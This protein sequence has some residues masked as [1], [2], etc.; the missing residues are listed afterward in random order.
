M[1]EIVIDNKNENIR[2][3]KYLQKILNDAP[4]SFIYKNIR[5]KNIVLNDKKTTYN[6]KLQIGDVIKLYLSDETI[7]K[8]RSKKE[9]AK[10]NKSFEIIYEDENILIVNKPVGL[11]SQKSAPNDISLNEQLLSYINDKGEIKDDFTPG[12]AHR[13]DRNTQGLV[14]MPKNNTCAMTISEMIKNKEI[15]KYYKTIVAG[16]IDDTFELKGTLIKN[17]ATNTVEYNSDEDLSNAHAIFTPIK[18]GDELTLLEVD[19]RTGKTHQIR[20][21]LASI[22]H[23]IIGDYKYGNTMLNDKYKTKFNI[24]SQMLVAYK[25]VF[26][27]TFPLSV[28]NLNGKIFTCKENDKF[29]LLND[30]L[31]EKYTYQKKTLREELHGDII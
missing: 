12:I 29:N 8:F 13:L 18:I 6:K 15:K 17:S 22:G 24:T 14:I 7:N 23:P 2:I 16:L 27:D 30:Y 4:M 20:A 28:A 9:I 1:L 19:L 31:E 21:Q 3:D 5:K 11:L 26:P 25:L 10:T